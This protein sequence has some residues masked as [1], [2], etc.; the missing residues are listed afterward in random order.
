[1]DI[2]VEV[3]GNGAAPLGV[4]EAILGSFSFPFSDLNFTS[5]SVF[6]K[7]FFEDIGGWNVDFFFGDFVF[8][9]FISVCAAG[10]LARWL[11][12]LAA[13]EGSLSLDLEA[14][15]VMSGFLYTLFHARS[16]S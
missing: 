2:A 15:G 8:L 10:P 14:I 16:L 1:M 5:I 9:D 13:M 7:C 12:L 11:G 3:R 4:A 6:L